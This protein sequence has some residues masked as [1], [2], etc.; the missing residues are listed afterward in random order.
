MAISIKQITLSLV[1]FFLCFCSNWST[2]QA[3]EGID[4][5]TWEEA[6]AKMEVEKRKIFVDVYT[7]WCT[8]CKKMDETTLQDPTIASYLNEFYYP[9]KLNAQQKEAITFREVTY[10]YIEKGNSSYHELAYQLMSG[11]MKY[12][13]IVFLDESAQVI[14]SIPG[15]RTAFELELFMT[16]FGENNHQKQPWSRFKKEQSF[17]KRNNNSLNAI[18]SLNSINSLQISIGNNY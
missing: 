17:Y 11:K 9:V 16:Y 13:T 15:Y 10:E 6:M 7:D 5:L 8:W 3:Q 2:L 12:P 1:C 14:Q 18:N 4:W